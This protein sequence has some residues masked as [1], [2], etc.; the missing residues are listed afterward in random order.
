[1]ANVLEFTDGNFSDEVL[2]ASVNNAQ[3]HFAER[4]SLHSPPELTESQSVYV[5]DNPKT[6]LTYIVNIYTRN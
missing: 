6:K 4:P 2:N 3:K 1:M 5:A